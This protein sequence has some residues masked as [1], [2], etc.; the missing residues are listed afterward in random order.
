MG[1][2]GG[3]TVVVIVALT[4]AER[5]ARL[6]ETLLRLQDSTAQIRIR[7]AFLLLVTFA[8]LA[9]RLGLEVILGAFVAG[10]LLAVLDPDYKQTHPKF[11]EKLEAIGFGVFIPVFFVASGVQF[12]ARSLFADSS[13]ILRVPL[14][15]AALLVLRGV[16][17][18]LYQARI[19]RPL[20]R[21]AGLLQ[22]TTLPF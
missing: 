12:D 9:V 5:S 8:A 6:A 21:V 18:L 13:T 3:L 11:H 7:G 20:S 10:A 22:A 16:P 2:F 15:L 14:F 17:A 4:M 1:C 19:G